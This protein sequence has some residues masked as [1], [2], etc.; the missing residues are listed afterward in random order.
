MMG[1]AEGIQIREFVFDRG[2]TGTGLYNRALLQELYQSLGLGEDDVA[3]K[4]KVNVSYNQ[5]NKALE[6]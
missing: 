4:D 6:N 5:G 2:L 1:E 3:R